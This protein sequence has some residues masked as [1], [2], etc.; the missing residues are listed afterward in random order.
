M[1]PTRLL[2]QI[3]VTQPWH[4][5]VDVEDTIK[6]DHAAPELLSFRQLSLIQ[7]QV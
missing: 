4:Q 6:G 7:Q 2:R 1:Q 3:D 5:I